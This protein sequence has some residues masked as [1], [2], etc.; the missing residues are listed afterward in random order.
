MKTLRTLPPFFCVPAIVL[1]NSVSCYAFEIKTFNDEN[2]SL[3]SPIF[4]SAYKP[5][6]YCSSYVLQKAG[7][8][9]L[10]VKVNPLKKL[11]PPKGT[12]PVMQILNKSIWATIPTPEPNQQNQPSPWKF[13]S[14]GDKTLSGSLTVVKYKPWAYKDGTLVGIDLT[15]NPGP[16]QFIG[17]GQVGGL[18][19]AEFLPGI[20]DPQ[21][22]SKDDSN[23]KFHW[24][25]IVSS[26]TTS[27]IFVTET[28]KAENTSQ[29][30]VKEEGRV[31]VGGEQKD[32]AYYNHPRYG[33]LFTPFY[34]TGFDAASRSAGQFADV[35]F[36][37]FEIEN[38]N[39]HNWS[40]DLYLVQQLEGNQV[41]IYDGIRYGWSSSFTK[42]LQAALPA[43]IP[44][45]GS[46]TSPKRPQTIC[47]RGWPPSCCVAWGFDYSTNGV[48]NK[49]TLS[50]DPE[51]QDNSI[52]ENNATTDPT[53]VPSPALLPTLATAGIYHGRKWR[54][55][56]QTQKDNDIAA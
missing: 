32:T 16:T 23:N 38:K 9:S 55:R 5:E 27:E 19:K 12:D 40:A 20:N 24:I 37:A 36:R 43:D 18:F 50:L 14:A 47:G 34:D 26:N 4:C 51:F 15:E 17:T 39:G 29:Y 11:A 1:I 30:G 52:Y 2:I 49:G 53:A 22:L 13:I 45:S 8:G 25:Q 42:E 31:D 28:R 10:T 56:K 7:W 33:N 21:P 3:T 41:E 44:S 6:R 46:P 48:A 54:K 35:P